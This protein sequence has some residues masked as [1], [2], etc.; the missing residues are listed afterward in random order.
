M[1]DL[2]LDEIL[3][4]L[5]GIPENTK[6]KPLAF[7]AKGTPVVRCRDE[8]GKL[9]KDIRISPEN[10]PK[11]ISYNAEMREALEELR[12]KNNHSRNTMYGILIA[13]GVVAGATFAMVFSLMK[14][15][16]GG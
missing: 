4:E 11:D 15:L 3:L 6:T 13:M 14:Y 2:E 12:V 16:P 9:L 5:D 7:D 1:I 10:A 8:E